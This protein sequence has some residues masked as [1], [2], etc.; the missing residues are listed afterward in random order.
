MKCLRV[1]G[2]AASP[3]PCGA[4]A[5]PHHH[6]VDQVLTLRHPKP[7]I[8]AFENSSGGIWKDGS[9]EIGQ[10]YL[11][12]SS[13]GRPRIDPTSPPSRSLG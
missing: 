2:R 13:S 3:Q 6:D 4:N 5:Q 11:P 7:F 8:S 12:L 1:D 9:A 10:R